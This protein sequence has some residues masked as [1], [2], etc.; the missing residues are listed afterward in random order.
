MHSPSQA[1]Q[2]LQDFHQRRPGT[3]PEAF[4]ALS[5]PGVGSSYAALV[6]TLPSSSSPLS[7]MD[8][9][10][11]DG[12]LL[13]LLAEQKP[14]LQLIGVDMSKTELLAADARLD[15]RCRLLNE[16]AQ[17]LSLATASVDV[18]L[19]HLALMLMDDI[20]AVLAQIHRVLRKGGH[21][22]CIVGR[23]FLLGD[24]GDA[25][26]RAFRSVAREVDLAH[27]PMGDQRTASHNGWIALLEEHFSD[28]R[29]DDLDIE[30][31]PDFAELWQALNG[32]Y[33][34]GRLTP[35][36]ISL[37]R[38]RLEIAAT[39]LQDADGRLATGWGLRLIRARAA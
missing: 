37:L 26:L 29:C 9:A 15:G 6:A 32:S 38:Q 17:A 39:A 28:I 27:L 34:L 31:T 7:V 19:S 30:W 25:Y 13:Q 23:G 20:D 16:R 8:L 2:F 36:G 33:D 12:Y 5:I 3:T 18:V 21:F 24:V 14:E 4:A 10:C 35:S 11:G 22:A 1:E